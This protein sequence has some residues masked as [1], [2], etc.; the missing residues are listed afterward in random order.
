MTQPTQG[1]LFHSPMRDTSVRVGPAG[2]N[3]KDWEGTVY[4]AG[5]GKAFDP[6][7][8]L[9]EYFDAVEINSS[10]YSPPRPADAAA[11]ARRVHN[12]PR[13]RFTAKAWQRSTHEPK[14]GNRSLRWPRTARPSGIRSRP[15]RRPEG[16]APS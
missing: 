4:P 2:W 3:Y 12:N 9:A 5:L 14:A 10:F 6:L 11:W 8:F 16:W 13:F 7:A 1:S 15:S